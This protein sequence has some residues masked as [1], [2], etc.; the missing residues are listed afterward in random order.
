MKVKGLKDKLENKL[1]AAKIDRQK[2]YDIEKFT[3]EKFMKK[4]DEIQKVKMYEEE[5]YSGKQ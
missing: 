1:F 4:F 5:I 2:I 3:M